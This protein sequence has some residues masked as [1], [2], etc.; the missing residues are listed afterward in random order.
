[1]NQKRALEEKSNDYSELEKKYLDLN[2]VELLDPFSSPIQST[3][4][5]E[6]T[7]TVVIPARN[8]ESSILSC[9]MSIEQSS[10]NLNHQNRLQVVVVDDGSDD[11]TWELIKNN[12]FAL[13]LTGVKQKHH[14]QAQA[15]N[16]G[17]SVSENEIIICC[18]ADMVLSYYAIEHFI[19][20]HQQFPNILLAGFRSDVSKNSLRVN[21]KYIRENGSHQYSYFINDERITFPIPGFP[22]NMCLTSSH[23]KNLGHLRGLWM[24]NNYD[25]WLLSDLVVG[26]LFSLPKS[27][28]YKI[29]GYDERLIGYGCTDGYLASKAIS[30]GNFVIPVYAAS[31]LHISH[32]SRTG[33][34][35]QEYEKNRQLF[36]K[37][38]KSSQIDNYP[39]WLTHAK[40]RIIESFIQ[41]PIS[42]NTIKLNKNEVTPK[43][44]QVDSLLALGKFTESLSLLSKNT[45]K[46]DRGLA[47]R[48]GRALFGLH[49]YYAAIYSFKKAT[50]SIPEAAINIAMSQAANYQ[51]ELAHKTFRQF[52]SE[53][54]KSA[55]L[56]FWS[57]QSIQDNIT[58]GKNFLNQG[59]Y[60][61]AIRC[62][63]NTLICEPDNNKAL[64]YV[65]KC[66]SSRS[67]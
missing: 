45:T 33:N 10:F 48:R 20:R 61:T 27:T 8:V 55:L 23:F 16:T 11:S 35:Q 29:G 22:D 9:L 54:S 2:K 51:F 36:L 65:K 41:K 47:F 63:E 30:A 5:K 15:L 24:R 38:L 12:K 26:A 52:V 39:N 7:A 67:D 44:Y 42:T 58:Q 4:T 59:F 40:D 56:P 21:S 32:F 37:F 13:N 64:K 1:M 14:G 46:N 66:I 62:F 53:N 49:K 50:S 3:R 60:D 19:L 6:L 43:Y 28:Y 17:I 31:G 57:K 25:P 34:K 18:D